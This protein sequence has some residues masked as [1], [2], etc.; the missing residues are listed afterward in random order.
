MTQMTELYTL[1]FCLDRLYKKA[2]NDRAKTKKFYPKKPIVIRQNRKTF[3]NNFSEICTHF[4]RPENDVELF[5]HER[6]QTPSSIKN[7]SLCIDNM[8]KEDQIF[9]VIMKYVDTYVR[10]PQ[11]LCGSGN[12]KLVREDRVLY[13]VCNICCSKKAVG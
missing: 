9:D 6:L 7:N 12:T 11:E 13:L 10:C 5:I 8:F 4:N 3:I 1:D 2:E